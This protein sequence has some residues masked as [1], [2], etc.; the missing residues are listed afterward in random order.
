MC[1]VNLTFTRMFWQMNCYLYFYYFPFISHLRKKLTYIFSLI[2]SDTFSNQNTYCNK[3]LSITIANYHQFTIRPSELNFVREIRMANCSLCFLC[4]LFSF[5]VML[6]FRSF[7]AVH[8]VLSVVCA[9][10]NIRKRKKIYIWLC[11]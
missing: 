9:L 4:S 3:K 10:I 1:A 11:L 7:N 2:N 8:L 5:S 6:L